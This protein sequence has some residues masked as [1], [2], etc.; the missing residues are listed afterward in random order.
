MI[1]DAA[2]FLENKTDVVL[3]ILWKI[4]FEFSQKNN[5]IKYAFAI[6]NIK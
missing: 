3:F 2:R 4:D 6:N 1:R 5:N